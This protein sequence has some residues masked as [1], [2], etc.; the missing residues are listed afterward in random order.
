MIES[1]TIMI[2]GD[3]PVAGRT[4]EDGADELLVVE[5]QTPE[6]FGRKYSVPVAIETSVKFEQGASR[7]AIFSSLR[8]IECAAQVDFPCLCPSFNEGIKVC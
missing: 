6:Q 4:R 5:R 3:P 2:R 7:G 1:P 8:S